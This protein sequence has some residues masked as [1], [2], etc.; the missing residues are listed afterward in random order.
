MDEMAEGWKR[1]L[2][3]FEVWIQ[4]EGTEFMP[5][6]GYF[7]MENLRDL[8]DP[9]RIAWM[10]N[11]IDEIV[12]KRVDKC[13]EAG[14]ALEDFLPYMPGPDALDIVRSMIELNERIQEAMLHMSDTF[15]L[16]LEV[17]RSLG[18]EEIAHYLQTLADSEEDIRHHMSLYS[19]GFGKLQSM[20][21]VIPDEML[22]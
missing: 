6:T 15:N 5:W 12:P 22:G 21:L 17:H 2:D 16:M 20:G 3:A 19:Q 10:N 4:Y 9:E 11:M 13:R 18:F 14:V 1:V 7:S 8:T